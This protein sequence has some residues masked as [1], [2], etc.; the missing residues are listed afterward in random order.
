MLSVCRYAWHVGQVRRRCYR[1]AG[2]RVCVGLSFALQYQAVS[3]PRDGGLHSMQPVGRR[4]RAWDR[5]QVA[6]VPI[7]GPKIMENGDANG[8]DAGDGMAWHVLEAWKA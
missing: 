3:R 7:P 4:V 2:S 1:I 8:E 6:L 5:L